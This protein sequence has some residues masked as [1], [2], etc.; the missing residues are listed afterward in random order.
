MIVAARVGVGLQDD[1]PEPRRAGYGPRTGMGVELAEDR[2]HMK[3]DRVLAD[4]Q[5]LSDRL[6]GQARGHQLQHLHLTGGQ[7]LHGRE[8]GSISR[9]QARR[10]SRIE[11]EQPSRP[12]AQ[13]RNEAGGVHVAR[14]EAARAAGVRGR[15]RRVLR[16]EHEDGGRFFH[17]LDQVER[18]AGIGPSIP[19]H[20]VWL[21]PL[22]GRREVIVRTNLS[23]DVAIRLSTE[24]RRQPGP[25]QRIFSDDENAKR[26][27]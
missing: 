1:E 13:R 25:R 7:V 16:E 10:E 6:I 27:F 23:D 9:R 21:A 15:R 24:H 14:Q 12:R 18:E 5:L 4:G 2:V 17:H 8:G 11:H 22:N 20:D 3:F 19:E 26:P